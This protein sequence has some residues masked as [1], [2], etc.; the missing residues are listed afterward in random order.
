MKKV[1]FLFIALALLT[2]V[3]CTTMYYVKPV[4]FYRSDIVKH[5][6][7][8]PI[9]QE[10]TLDANSKVTLKELRL[11]LEGSRERISSTLKEEFEK[12]GYAITISNKKPSE[13]DRN[14]DSERAMDDAIKTFLIP[15]GKQKTTGT[16]KTKTG[17]EGYVVA[18]PVPYKGLVDM[19]L[20]LKPLLPKAIDTVLFLNINSHI[21]SGR[22]SSKSRSHIKIEGRLIHLPSAETIASVK[23]EFENRTIINKRDVSFVIKDMLEEFPVRL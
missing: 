4:A 6:Y 8:M 5:I 11:K 14:I 23:R 10:V 12:R 1:Y 13:L 16:V 2:I 19:T 18:G 20:S 22:F 17:E 3:G 15:P 21:G 9:A 7:V